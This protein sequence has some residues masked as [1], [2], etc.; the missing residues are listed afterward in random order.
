M[1]HRSIVITLCMFAA[2]AAIATLVACGGG[3]P[4][5]FEA[6]GGKIAIIFERDGNAKFTQNVR[7]QHATNGTGL[8]IGP[9]QLPSLDLEGNEKD[10]VYWRL[11]ENGGS[12]EFANITSNAVR[13]IM[14]KQGDVTFGPAA[15]NGAGRIFAGS[16]TTTE[17]VNARGGFTAD[18][19]PGWTGSFKAKGPAGKD[20]VVTVSKGIVTAV[21]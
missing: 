13:L 4:V 19:A 15:T 17:T 18:G 2:S 8:S 11:R 12:L 16:L 21:K 6:E 1:T 20:V 14:E 7:I 3:L 5:K 10:A 9:S